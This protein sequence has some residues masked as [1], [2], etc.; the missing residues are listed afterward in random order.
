MD[1]AVRE[2]GRV[3]QVVVVLRE[4]VEHG[5]GLVRRRTV[6]AAGLDHGDDADVQRLDRIRYDRLVRAHRRP[7][8]GADV[9]RSQRQVRARH[10]KVQRAALAAM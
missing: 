2:E 9:A 4:V 5:A 6:R 1:V 7:A 8:R 10:G 3:V